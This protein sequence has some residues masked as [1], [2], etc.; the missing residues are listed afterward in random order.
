MWLRIRIPNTV[1]WSGFLRARTV[2]S[3][4]GSVGAA[5]RSGVGW[6]AVGRRG[7]S[8]AGRTPPP[9]WPGAPPRSECPRWPAAPPPAAPPTHTNQLLYETADPYQ[10]CGSGFIPYPDF[11]PSR[12]SDPGY[13]IPD[14]KSRISDPKTATKEMGEKKLVVMPFY[15]I[16]II[17]LLKC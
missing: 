1:P 16:E 15:K 6:S 17:L 2:D 5:G 4:P 14:I 3:P 7:V 12:I 10:C 8:V 13:R 9:P 11:Y